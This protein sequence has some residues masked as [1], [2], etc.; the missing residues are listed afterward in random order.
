MCLG[1]GNGCVPKEEK[2][3]MSLLNQKTNNDIINDM[4]IEEK[5]EFL[6]QI[7]L[8][9]NESDCDNC[10]IKL[11]RECTAQG[12]KQWLMQEAKQ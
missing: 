8:C 7:T 1:L 2:K 9:C 6:Q 10:P 12:I 5:A 11:K 3:T 4:S